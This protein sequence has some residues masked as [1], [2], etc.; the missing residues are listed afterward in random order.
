MWRR[1]LRAAGA[2][3]YPL[4]VAAVQRALIRQT[5]T[6]YDAAAA[7][8]VCT[9]ANASITSSIGNIDRPRMWTTR[10]ASFDTGA[11]R[12][13]HGEPVSPTAL[14]RNRSAL[15]KDLE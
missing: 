9:R 3:D 14:P 4:I 6:D 11:N 10:S 1:D 8:L 13:S 15:H 12:Q 2:T 7:P 5:R